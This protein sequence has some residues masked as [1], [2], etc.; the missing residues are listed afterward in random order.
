M[1][2]VNITI[3]SDVEKH[4]KALAVTRNLTLE[5]MIAQSFT[6]GLK[7]L[8]YRHVRNQKQWGLKKAREQRIKELEQK[9]E[10]MGVGL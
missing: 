5:E 9:L 4:L 8:C 7:D 3:E 2:T 6:H 10:Q 1:K